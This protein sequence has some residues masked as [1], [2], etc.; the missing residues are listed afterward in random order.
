MQIFFITFIGETVKMNGSI[1]SLWSNFKNS[2]P[3][4][5]PS[6]ELDLFNGPLRETW[7][8]WTHT[9]FLAFIN[10]LRCL[11]K[12]QPLLTRSSF[13]AR[14]SSV[15]FPL[16]FKLSLRYFP[17]ILFMIL[18]FTSL[19]R[20]TTRPHLVKELIAS[21][22]W[23]WSVSFI[24]HQYSLFPAIY[25]FSS[26]YLLL[27]Y[28]FKPVFAA[29]PT[30]PA[31]WSKFSDFNGPGRYLGW[32]GKDHPCMTIKTHSRMMGWRVIVDLLLQY[33]GLRC[34]QIHAVFKA[35]QR[36]AINTRV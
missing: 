31:P 14:A 5:L 32:M 27:F 30:F 29:V 1:G 24:C 13:K 3:L 20:E 6:S 12:D 23:G 25:H 16:S 35:W 34:A 18:S 10:Y 2:W 9:L 21:G 26:L 17:Y 8:N 28:G 15:H 36:F 4:K 19:Q 11:A 33:G 22:S 7:W